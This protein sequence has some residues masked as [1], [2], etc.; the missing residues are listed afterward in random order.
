M[1]ALDEETRRYVEYVAE[2]EDVDPR[3]EQWI[4]GI[5]AALRRNNERAYRK[6]KHAIRDAHAKSH[7]V[8]AGELIVYPDLPTPLRQGLFAEPRRYP[9]IARLSTTSGALRSDRTPG[10]RA[11]ALKVLDVSGERVIRDGTNRSQDFVFVDEPVF[12][13]ANAEEYRKSMLFASLLA[14]SPDSVISGLGFFVRAA[15]RFRIPIPIP[16]TLVVAAKVPTDVL[17]TTYYTAAP[18]RFGK[19]VAKICVAPLSPSVADRRG[20]HL[21][22]NGGPDIHTEMVAAF[23]AEDLA[24]YEVR[25]QL[26]TDK[27]RMPI[28][29]ATVEWPESLSPYLPVGKIVF[30]RQSAGSE[31]RRRYADDVM[32]F[33]SWNG[34]EAHRPL[35]SINRIKL[36]AYVESSIFRHERNGVPVHEPM[37][38]AE[39]PS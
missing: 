16:A 18:L 10:V 7:G 27:A 34:L 3:E 2:I 17:G 5:V 26:L 38:V 29:D 14:M 25:A 1:S 20:Q 6:Y 22:P 31:A 13:I 11:L 35:G 15:R 19:Y 4:D 39:L 23:F 30:P 24:E 33:N 8:L 37:D 36:R 12:P 28:E 21:P 32:S 9:V